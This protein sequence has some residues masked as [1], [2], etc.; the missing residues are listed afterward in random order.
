MWC[1][2]SAS[3]EFAVTVDIA[4]AKAQDVSGHEQ[5]DT[6]NSAAINPALLCTSQD[7]ISEVR[8]AS[9]TSAC[10]ALCINICVVHQA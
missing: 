7:T 3:Q 8:A 1:A 4:S 10:L 9:K 2:D 6:V 5:P